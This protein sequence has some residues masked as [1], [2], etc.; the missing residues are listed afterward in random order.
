MG[1]TITD[2][3]LLERLGISLSNLYATLRGNVT[4][5]KIRIPFAKNLPIQL[6]KQQEKDS[7]DQYRIDGRLSLYVSQEQATNNLAPLHQE[8]LTITVNEFPNDAMTMLYQ[9]AKERYPLK[10]FIDV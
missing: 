6:V 9:K 10:N 8:N 7:I 3:V 5:T 1:F 4:I 2:P